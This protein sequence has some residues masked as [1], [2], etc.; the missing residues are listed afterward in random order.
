MQTIQESSATERKNEATLYIVGTPIGNLNDISPR[1]VQAFTDADVVWCE[2]TRVTVKLLNHLNIS[3]PLERC[4][5]NIIAS[6]VQD[7]LA[8][9]G[10]GESIAFA[11]DAGM[12]GISDPGQKLI[13]TAREAGFRVVVIPGPSASICALV[14]SG[15]ACDHFFFEGFLPRK[16]GD[17]ERRLRRLSCVPG[18][19]LFYE[20]PY[21]VVDTLKTIAKVFPTRMVALCRELTKLHEEVIRTN[22]TELVEIIEQRENLR[23]EMVV[24]VAPPSVEEEQQFFLGNTMGED[25]ISPEERL[26]QEIQQA[27][28]EGENVSKLAK[29]LSTRF[30]VKRREVYELAL[31]M[32]DNVELN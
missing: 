9:L 12:P 23:G 5:E 30:S 26:R 24:V 11:S 32:K 21:R 31:S 14:S 8:R 2:D 16:A 4:D 19:L 29:R 18:A 1:V 3:K 20:S 7:A 13:D 25:E 10:A 28:D 6:R 27:L 15:I 22:A 17:R